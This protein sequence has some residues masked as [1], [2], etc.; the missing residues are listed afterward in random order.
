MREGLQTLRVVEAA[1][2]S[3][4]CSFLFRAFLEGYSRPSWAQVSAV[5]RWLFNPIVPV[6]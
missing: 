4:A 2:A 3:I 1:L 6:L 5:V